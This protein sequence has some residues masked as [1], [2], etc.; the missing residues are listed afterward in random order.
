MRIFYSIYETI[1]EALFPLSATEKELF[2]YSTEN[3]YSI[4][5]KAP[6]YSGLAV[7]L[8]EAHSIFAYKDKRVEQF[9][10]NIKYKKSAQAIKMG[11]FVLFQYIREVSTHKN[12]PNSVVLIL[13]IPIT[14]RRR[15]ERGYNQCELLTD[16]M[17]KLFNKEHAHD[18]DN[19]CNIIFENNLLIRTHHDSRHTLKGRADRIESA[20]GIFGINEARLKMLDVGFKNNEKQNTGNV[21]VVIIDDVITT[22]STMREA[23]DTMKHAGFQNVHALS[24]AH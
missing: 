13:P 6:P 3:I 23:I 7:P 11:S 1:I 20:K 9:I 19:I 16:D 5:Q 21:H 24:L 4:L 22:G 17:K 14:L 15:H 12:D 2:S 18:Q 8:P 10:W